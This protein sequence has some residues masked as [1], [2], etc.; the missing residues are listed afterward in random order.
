MGFVCG[1]NHQLH[2]HAHIFF[3]EI[4]RYQ[5][6]VFLQVGQEFLLG[7]R[8]GGLFSS[9]DMCANIILPVHLA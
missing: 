8:V 4:D 5:A 6:L 1:H 7:F 3:I 9:L 2:E